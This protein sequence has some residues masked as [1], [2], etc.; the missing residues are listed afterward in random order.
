[1]RKCVFVGASRKDSSD[2]ARV[3]SVRRAAVAV[4]EQME[5]RTLLTKIVPDG[6]NVQIVEVNG[7]NGNDTIV[8]DGNTVKVNGVVKQTFHVQAGL[9]VK[10]MGGTDTISIN[11][12]GAFLLI[13]AV[14]AGAGNDVVNVGGGNFDAN[15][16]CLVEAEQSEVVNLDDH[17]NNSGADIFISSSSITSSQSVG[18]IDLLPG[19]SQKLKLTM[20][21]GADHIDAADAVLPITATLGG[22]ADSM[23]SGEKNDSISGGAG[24]DT[25]DGFDGNDTITGDGDNDQ[26]IGENGNDVI[27]G[28]DGKDMLDGGA[29]DDKIDGGAGDDNLIG[30]SGN[31]SLTGGA[32]SDQETGG[33]GSDVYLFAKATSLEL[34]TVTEL[35]N[36]AGNDVLDFSAMTTTVQVDLS[37]L[38]LA[39]M[40]DRS[41]SPS[42]MSARSFETAIGGTA[43]D[44][45]Q[46]DQNVATTLIGNGGKDTL[47]GGPGSEL[48]VGGA[49]DDLLIGSS[50]NDTL[51]GGDGS[52]Q[53]LGGPGND[54]YRFAKANA[55]QTDT[56]QEVNGP[57]VDRL[58]FSA[59]TTQVT[60]NLLS[61]TLAT[62]T[63]RTVKTQIAGE[64]A[65]IEQV[66]GGSAA[67]KITGNNANNTLIGNGGNDTIFGNGGSDSIEG[68]AGNDQLTGGA[69]TDKLFGGNNN[70]KL[71]GADGSKDTLDGGS[72]M[73]SLGSS[74][75]IDVKV[76]IP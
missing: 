63:N 74:D 47:V 75:A 60:V 48:L 40:Q 17:L 68:D 6:G 51:D 33:A 39:T 20:G 2:G 19:H 36:D 71:F 45:L 25:V 72:G 64:F 58:D 49:G 41:I 57:D 53:L 66:I 29:N 3:K 54:V 65:F 44:V 69:G 22:G 46:S 5:P 24:N 13:V 32:G 28:G 70:D 27:S 18:E 56:I 11:K 35:Q 55:A 42:A 52:D 76:S 15:I 8:V 30:G 23:F 7:T 31:D 14:D 37:A 1:M 61:D 38:T 4:V 34:D 59:M 50:G 43:G 73:D 12:T 9:F 16:K 67:D 62:M 10:A 26:I 21:N